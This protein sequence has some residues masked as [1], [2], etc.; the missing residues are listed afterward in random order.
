MANLR[1]DLQQLC[2]DTMMIF[3]AVHTPLFSDS[4]REDMVP[5]PPDP[6]VIGTLQIEA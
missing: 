5:A 6:A 4:K 3:R 2:M 1:G